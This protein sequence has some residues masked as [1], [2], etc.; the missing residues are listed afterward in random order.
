MPGVDREDS[1]LSVRKRILDFS[2]PKVAENQG[3][4]LLACRGKWEASPAAGG[5][6]PLEI[7]VR[8]G[9]MLDDGFAAL[10]DAGSAIKGRLCVAFVSMHG[11]LEAGLD[12]GGLVKEFLEEVGLGF[13]ATPKPYP[14]P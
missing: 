8:R 3:R 9:A 12:Y 2:A 4:Q 11:E 14:K 10:R 6:R 5:P 1:G 7:T 13:G